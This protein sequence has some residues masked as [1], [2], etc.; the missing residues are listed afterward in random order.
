MKTPPWPWMP[1]EKIVEYRKLGKWGAKVSEV[2]L[3]SWLTYGG[4]VESEESIKQIHFAFAHGINFF[5]TANVYAHGKSEEVVG[6]AV[7][8]IGRDEV[9]LAT[10]VFF[11]MG[12]GPNDRGL[13]RKHVW[14][15]CHASLRRLKTEYIDL[16]QC[17]RWDP[18]VPM[19][20][21]VMTMDIL[22][23][24]GKILYWGVSEWPAAQIQLAC[25]IAAKLNAPPP[26]SNQP[27][28]N[29]L[30]RGIESDVIPT[31]WKN[32]MGQ[33]VFSPLAQGVLTGKYKPNQAP[34]KDSRAAAEREGVFLRGRDT[35]S[36]PSLEKVE[37]LGEIAKELNL[38]TAQLALAWILRKDEISS[39]IIGATK[40]SQIEE[41]L[42]ATGKKLPA[43]VLQRI[44]ETLNNVPALSA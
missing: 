9:F 6:K 25:D 10:K 13:S 8:D 14:E 3:G 44:D 27:C 33:V 23:R 4:S 18:E 21:L 42:A 39:V 24:Q 12:D 20:E 2:A 26:V 15:Q 17:H 29:M 5:D 7:G 41:N 11:P 37:K 22:T 38:S 28:Y 35:M 19:E 36:T 43:D 31:S 32:G 16:Y 30:Q 34:P 1:K 40:T